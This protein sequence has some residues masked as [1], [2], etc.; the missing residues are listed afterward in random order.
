MR[1]RIKWFVLLLMIISV[2]LTVRGLL[3]E[4]AVPERAYLQLDINGTYV[5]APPQ[6]LLGR[7][8]ASD[9][10]TLVDLLANIRKAKVDKRIKGVVARIGAL[11]AGWAKVEDIRDAL[12][13]FKKSGKPLI[14]VLQQEVTG[15]NREYYLASVC[16]RIYLPPSATAPLVGLAAHFTFLGEVWE[17]LDIDM[18]VEKV[19]EYKTF[20]DMIGYKEMTAAHR[21]MAN[22]LLDSLNDHFVSTIAQARGLEADDIRALID[23]C[24]I[25]PQDFV[26]AHLADGAKYLEDLHD[27]IGGDEM[28]LLNARDYAQVSASSLKL[29]NGPQIAVV[30]AVGGI[31]SGEGGRSVQGE[32]LGSDRLIKALSDAAEDGDIKAIVFRIDSPGG[33]ALASDLIWRATQA[34]Q[35]KKPI[36]VSMSDVAGSGGYY[37]AAGASRIVAQPTTLTG[38]IGV[39]FAR[40]N[41]KGLLNK[42]GVHTETITRGRFAA[43]DDLTTKLEPEGRAK[44]VEEMNHV[45]D[46]FVERVANGRKLEPEQVR[47]VARG[48]VWTGAQAKE[49]GLVDTLGGFAVALQEAKAAAGL[50]ADAEVELVFYPRPEHLLERIAKL[51]SVRMATTLPPLLQNALRTL[52]F[53]FHEGSI[54]TL[55][56]ESVEIR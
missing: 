22:S 23:R 45:Y 19:A 40:P 11:D 48:R 31:V 42:I 7:F 15:A 32:V 47:D 4:P 36:V 33:S 53:P 37:I 9:E 28:P 56:P 3:K 2:V 34:A 35:K 20:G 49:K 52:A 26:D 8:F 55:M 41:I 44:L 43:V 54:L 50:K 14:A 39:V 5:E 25:Q 12:A 29:D 10:H 27:E 30:Y 24:P 17:K 13:D 6:D 1:K 38:S 51:L 16:D 18:T 21:E 46:V